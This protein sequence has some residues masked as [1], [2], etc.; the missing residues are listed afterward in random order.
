MTDALF[1]ALFWKA[2][3]STDVF[4]TALKFF[5]NQV[6]LIFRL[7][8]SVAYL[9]LGFY[10]LKMQPLPSP[11]LN[12]IFGITCIAYGVF[13]GVRSLTRYKQKEQ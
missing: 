3:G 6:Q 8:L 13:R 7:L 10:V 1:T 5:M 9:V 4:L 2:V 12:L 11:T